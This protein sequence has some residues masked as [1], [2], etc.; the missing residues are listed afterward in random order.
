MPFVNSI[1][2]PLSLRNWIKP[3]F[4]HPSISAAIPS[5]EEEAIVL[6]ET[7]K[8]YVDPSHVFSGAFLKTFGLDGYVSPTTEYVNALGETGKAEAEDGSLPLVLV[9]PALLGLPNRLGDT[10]KQYIRN[11]FGGWD[12]IIAH[13]NGPS[14]V[15]AVSTQGDSDEALTAPPKRFSFNFTGKRLWNVLALPVKLLVILPLKIIGIPFKIALNVVKLVTEFLPEVIL[16]YTG[17]AMGYFVGKI[18]EATALGKVSSRQYPFWQ[19]LAAY[20]VLSIPIAVLGAIHYAARIFALIGTAVTS[21]EKSARSAWEYGRALNSKFFGVVFGTLG[22]TLSIALTTVMWIVLFPLMVSEILV[23]IPQLVPLLTAISHWP[24]VASSLTFVQGTF[25]LVVGSLPAA[26][27]AAAT[28]VTGALGI[29]VSATVLAVAVTIAVIAAPV[30]TIASRIADEL[31]NIWAR[32][33]ADI[34]LADA[35]RAALPKRGHEDGVLLEPSKS[36]RH[37]AHAHTADLGHDFGT[38]TYSPY[39]DAGRGRNRDEAAPVDHSVPTR[40]FALG[41]GSD[42]E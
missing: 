6:D 19:V 30:T 11:L 8:P 28:A 18:N 23:L 36:A 7:V 35:V 26:F 4:V 3:F 20:F 10:W 22:A 38:P 32:W 40:G 16:N 39:V 14:E 33:K 34:G 13:S 5:T 37:H 17:M 15:I 31:S 41:A 42:S 27:A 24:I 21:P 12:S 29:A 1:T 9:L 2:R 25:A